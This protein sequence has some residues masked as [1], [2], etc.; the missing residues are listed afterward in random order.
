MEKHQ[1]IA[2]AKRLAKRTNE[3]RVVFFEDDGWYHLR[4]W[5]AEETLTQGQWQTGL[6]INPHGE[7]EN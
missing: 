5:L 1:A 2:Q 6:T 7:I 4:E 3:T